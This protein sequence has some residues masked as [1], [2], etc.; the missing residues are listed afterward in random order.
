[1]NCRGLLVI[2]METIGFDKEHP[3]GLGER[4]KIGRNGIRWRERKIKREGKRVL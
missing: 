4:R 3:G 1:M 2:C